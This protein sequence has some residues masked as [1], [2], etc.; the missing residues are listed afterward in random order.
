MATKINTTVALSPN[1]LVGPWN[2]ILMLGYDQRR[3]VEC[4]KGRGFPL[5]LVLFLLAGMWPTNGFMDDKWMR[6]MMEGNW[7]PETRQAP[8]QPVLLFTQFH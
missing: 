4:R 5:V 8:R 3:G 1:T 7:P 2:N 6:H